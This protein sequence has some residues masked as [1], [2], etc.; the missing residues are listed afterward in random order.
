M[1]RLHII[2]PFLATCI[3]FVG[4][5]VSCL[6]T[7]AFAQIVGTA[8]GN[9]VTAI[10]DGLNSNAGGSMISLTKEVTDH[11]LGNAALKSFGD[12]WKANKGGESSAAVGNLLEKSANLKGASSILSTGGVLI[13]HA[14]YASTAA[15]EIAGGSY[16]QGFITIADGLGKSVVSG[17]ASATGASFGS[18]GG[19]AGTIAG[20]VAGGYAGSEAWDASVG[21]LTSAVKEGLGKQEDKRQF[22]EM[23]GPKMV[24]RTPE[25]IHEAWLEYNKEL[26]D[27]KIQLEIGKSNVPVA[28]PPEKKLQEADCK[29]SCTKRYC[30]CTCPPKVWKPNPECWE[31][32]DPSRRVKLCKHDGQSCPYFAPKK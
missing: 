21:R 29:M 9:A 8:G 13:D 7:P 31:N 20:G 19:P 32:V 15:G 1:K 27:K 28:T 23:S 10:N 17:I 14:G 30:E 16:A 22:R 3:C 11:A 26:D 5:A 12:A 24:G 2:S 6:A 25:K 4:L 18:L